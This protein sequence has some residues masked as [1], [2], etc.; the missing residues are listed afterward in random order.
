MQ[1]PKSRGSF[2]VSIP[3]YLCVLLCKRS[4][5]LPCRPITNVLFTVIA[6]TIVPGNSIIAYYLY[7]EVLMLNYASSIKY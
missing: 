4:K 3:I 2:V 1:C 7:R 5:F 6:C